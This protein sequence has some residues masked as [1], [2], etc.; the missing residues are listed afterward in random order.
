MTQGPAAGRY[1]RALLWIRFRGRA[2]PV[3]PLRSLAYIGVVVLIGLAVCSIME[4]ALKVLERKE[5][6]RTSKWDEEDQ[7]ILANDREK[8]LATEKD[9]V[10]RSM[11]FS[12]DDDKA[13]RKRVLVVGDSFIWGHGYVNLND[14]W[15]RQL[16]RELN[17]RGYWDVQVIGAGL[18]GA[19]TH[20]E[21]RWLRDGDWL[22]R[23]R[24]DAIVIGYVT[25]DPNERDSKGDRLVDPPAAA[26][27]RFVSK[28][29]PLTEALG[30]LF[31]RFTE[32]I[33]GRVQ[34][35]RLARA[36]AGDRAQDYAIWELNLLQG[37]NFESY[38][39]TV[40]ELGSFRKSLT[41]PLFVFTTPQ[42]PSRDHFAPR[43]APVVPLFEQAAIPFFNCLDR[44]VEQHPLGISVAA[45]G[46]TPANAHPGTT[47]T[48][49]YATEVA[50]ILEARYPETL[51]KRSAPPGSLRPCIDD[52]MPCEVNPVRS[53]AG[54]W[55]LN[56]PNST[57]GML[58]LPLSTRHIA[59]CFELPVAAR[60]VHLRGEGRLA[61]EIFVTRVNPAIGFDDGQICPL[62]RREGDDLTWQVAEPALPLNTIRIALDADASP[63]LAK[64]RELTLEIQF[65]DP[66]V[67]P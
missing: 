46:I 52:W 54:T 47:T 28:R 2:C 31:P 66:A 36:P 1:C 30:W 24:P 9:P 43:Y 59:L 15:W 16:Q 20:D 25:N 22:K 62:G 17:H 38:R 51:G 64:S 14:V 6:I 27:T 58:E 55:K 61:A 21:L 37:K 40:G 26:S 48:H 11:G 8:V 18:C 42:Y 45:W 63:A 23:Y 29:G 13:G 53:S 7:R 50:D 10:W 41:I 32:Q 34:R 49:F 65:E 4:L 35:L 33:R 67:R 19:S 60:A 5:V 12:V 3:L 56:W 39:N 57:G 44:Y